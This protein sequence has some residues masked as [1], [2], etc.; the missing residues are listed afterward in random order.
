MD[1]RI[2]T[3]ALMYQPSFVYME[4]ILQIQFATGMNIKVKE[5][6]FSSTLLKMFQTKQSE[7]K[8]ILKR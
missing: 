1:L 8:T 4:F 6:F 3:A 7:K 2:C 5:M